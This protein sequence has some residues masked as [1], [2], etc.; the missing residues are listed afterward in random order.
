MRNEEIL[1]L[2]HLSEVSNAA[3]DVSLQD[4]MLLGSDE[5]GRVGSCKRFFA[6]EKAV[7]GILRAWGKFKAAVDVLFLRGSNAPGI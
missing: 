4:Q 3:A 5:L 2:H 6:A 7:A 1:T